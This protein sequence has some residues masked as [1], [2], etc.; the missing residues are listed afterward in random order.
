[1]ENGV[2]NL[3]LKYYLTWIEHGCFPLFLLLIT[4]LSPLRGLFLGKSMII[5]FVQNIPP[6]SADLLAY[7]WNIE[8]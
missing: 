4:P 5:K 6:E 8:C 3:S 7:Y 1:M 2:L